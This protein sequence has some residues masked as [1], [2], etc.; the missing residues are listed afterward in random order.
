MLILNSKHHRVSEITFIPNIFHSNWT[1]MIINNSKILNF[2]HRITTTATKSKSIAIAVA[3]R[4]TIATIEF[5]LTKPI[6]TAAIA[7]TRHRFKF[8][9]QVK[10][11]PTFRPIDGWKEEKRRNK[12][13]KKHRTP[14]ISK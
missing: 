4:P 7:Y 6:G 11:K 3:I 12:K 5:K 1:K 2:V 13:K 10:E 9:F 8:V 14:K